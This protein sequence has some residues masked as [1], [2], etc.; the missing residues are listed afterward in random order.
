MIYVFFYFKFFFASRRR[1]TSCALVTGVQTCALPIYAEAFLSGWTD[2]HPSRF[3]MVRR[4]ASAPRL[5]G[6]IG[7]DRRENGEV[8]L[9]YWVARSYW[10]RGY[11]TEAG[12]HMLDLARTLGIPRRTQAPS[13]ANPASAAVPRKPALRPP[14]R[15]IQRTR[16]G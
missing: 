3:L 11:A 6:G 8:E 15:P 2:G 1:H 16:P 13:A 5:I 14:G 12:R 10:G 7:I 9:G 4:T